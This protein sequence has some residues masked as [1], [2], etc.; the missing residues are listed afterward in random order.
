MMDQYHPFYWLGS[1]AFMLAGGLI[2]YSIGFRGGL[3]VSWRDGWKAG[4]EDVAYAV[5]HAADFGDETWSRWLLPGVA[6]PLAARM[7]AARIRALKGA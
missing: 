1:A 6:L 3:K 4:V 2:G 5:E 7:L